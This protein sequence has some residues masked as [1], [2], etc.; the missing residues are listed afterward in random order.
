MGGRIVIETAL[1]PIAAELV[2]TL[3]DYSLEDV[4]AVLARVPESDHA[5]LAKVLAAMVDP[6]ASVRDL[7]AWTKSGPVKSRDVDPGHKV[8]ASIKNSHPLPREHGSERGYQQHRSRDDM[9]ACEPCQV[10]HRKDEQDRRARR[11]A[12]EAEA[13]EKAS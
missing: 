2:G 13:L 7:L 4:D 12:R 3:R 6:D 5:A 10:A 8:L 1:V 11:L 9:P